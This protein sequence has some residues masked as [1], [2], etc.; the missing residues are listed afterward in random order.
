MGRTAKPRGRTHKQGFL[1]EYKARFAFESCNAQAQGEANVIIL[2]FRIK[3]NA[4]V[5]TNQMQLFPVALLLPWP[6]PTH[7]QGKR[8]LVFISSLACELRVLFLFE[9]LLL[10]K[11]K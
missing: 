9:H 10:Q 5:E 1:Q 7:N 3:S 11:S 6:W 2:S 4:T 8:Q